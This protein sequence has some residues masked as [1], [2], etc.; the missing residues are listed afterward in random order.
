M[1]YL[2]YAA[3]AWFLFGAFIVFRALSPDNVSPDEWKDLE[4]DLDGIR[5]G[6]GRAYYPVMFFLFAG[7]CLSAPYLAIRGAKR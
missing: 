7:L 3:L 5:K 2:A 1:T 4:K 6:T